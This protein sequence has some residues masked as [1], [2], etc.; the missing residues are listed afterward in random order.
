MGLRKYIQYK[1]I[2]TLFLTL[3]SAVDKNFTRNQITVIWLWL[4]AA[5]TSREI[6]HCTAINVISPP[7]SWIVFR[8]DLQLLFGLM[9]NKSKHCSTKDLPES[10]DISGAILCSTDKFLCYCVCW[11]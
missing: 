5:M 8:S 10:A 1:F 6:C 4:N 11:C 7:I 2:H 3:I 9:S